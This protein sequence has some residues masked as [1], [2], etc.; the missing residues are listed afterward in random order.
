MKNLTL[1]L[2]LI[3]TAAAQAIEKPNI[4]FILADDMGYGDCTAYNP[5]SKVVTPNIDRLAKEGLLFTDAHSASGTCTASRYGLLTGINPS[6]R[7]VVNGITGLG[8]VIE[9]HEVTVGELLQDQGYFTAM[10][11]KWH[12]G[13]AMKP[14]KPRPT[15]DFS[16]PLSGGPVD[17]GFDSFLGLRQAV[18]AA[19]YFYI[20]DRE[21]E[22]IPTETTEGTK[23]SAKAAGKNSRTAYGP[24]EIAPGFVPEKA[25]ARLSDEVVTILRDHAASGDEAK[26]LFLYYAMLQP[27]TPWLPEDRYEGKSGA[28]SYGDYLVQMDDEVGRV[29]EVLRETGLE[30]NTLVIFSSD[31]GAM[32]PEADIQKWG[33]RANGPLAGGKAR[34]EEGGHRVPFVARWPGQ[35]PAGTTTDATINHTDFLATVAELL[36]VDLGKAAPEAVKD[37]HS[38]LPVL[39]NG[40]SDHQR[41]AMAVTAGSFRSGEWKLTFNRGSR[42]AAPAEREASNASLYHLAEDLGE[43]QDLSA[44]MPERKREL[45][46]AYHE[47]FSDRKLKPLA[48][49]VAAKKLLKKAPPAPKAA[50]TESNLE[51]LREKRTELQK[52]LDSLLTNEQ[53]LAQA[54]ARKKALADGKGGVPLRNAMDAALNLSPEIKKQFDKLRKEISH[55]TGE[56]RKQP[57][58]PKESGS[59]KP[60]PKGNPSAGTAR[61]AGGVE[62]EGPSLHDAPR[63]A[64]RSVQVQAG[65]ER[66]ESLRIL[67]HQLRLEHSFRSR[68]AGLS[69]DLRWRHRS[70]PEE[71]RAHH[72]AG[73]RHA[74]GELLA[75]LDATGRRAVG[76]VQPQHGD[77]G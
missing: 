2:I 56:L 74:A 35:V 13:F 12:L 18:S 41:A 7:G 38:F 5:E 42:S 39:K 43:T 17:H 36:E 33:H 62:R 65:S 46:A 60:S 70:E 44:S 40:S 1:I 73:R 21:P 71:G 72:V 10:V 37:S 75:H 52:Q 29:L 4:I 23:A 48:E 58:A 57:T 19:P 28:G 54:A 6:R 8:P 45:F 15:F 24:G 49:Q 66:T 67:A 14:A 55:L 53:K 30:K 32:W 68:T 22:A 64:H 27:H 69:F 9:E 76:A 34:P 16:K 59:P 11:G 77:V 61:A 20:R 26:P 3:L 63:F 25:P 47:Y 51:E 50:A 31:N